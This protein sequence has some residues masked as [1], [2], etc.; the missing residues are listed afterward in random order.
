[1]PSIQPITALV[2]SA[3][4]S[5]ASPVEAAVIPEGEGDN[6]RLRARIDLSSVW[7]GIMRSCTRELAA[8]TFSE[9]TV[10]DAGELPAPGM[11]SFHLQTNAPW[12]IS[13]REAV[14]RP[15]GEELLEGCDRRLRAPRGDLEV[16][17]DLVRAHAQ[18]V[19]RERLGKVGTR[20]I[21]PRVHDLV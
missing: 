7:R 1:M 17:Q 9:F 20:R 21:G 18:A 6:Q 5:V 11:L 10:T 3:V 4:L 16:A 14:L 19:V 13:G 8:D 2:F 15:R 12:E